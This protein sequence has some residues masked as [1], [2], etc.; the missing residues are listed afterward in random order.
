MRDQK[1][2]TIIGAAMEM[3]KEFGSGFLEAVH[4]EALEHKRFVFYF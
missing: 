2:S 1:N 3:H 4:Q